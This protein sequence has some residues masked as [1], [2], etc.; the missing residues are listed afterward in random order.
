M[1]WV[2]LKENSCYEIFN[3]YPF[4][5]RDKIHGE[6]IKQRKTAEGCFVRIN[7]KKFLLHRI[8]ANNFVPN[9]ENQHRVFHIDNDKFNNHIE[10]LRWGSGKV[11][12]KTND[13]KKQ[14]KTNGDSQQQKMNEENEKCDH[15]EVVECVDKIVGKAYLI[16]A[17]GYKLFTDYYLYHDDILHFNGERFEILKK[18]DKGNNWEVKM[19][20]DDDKPYMITKRMIQMNR[21]SFLETNFDKL[22]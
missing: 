21:S 17:I 22:V 8:I 2:E 16:N 6:V 18:H 15:L 14:Q 12:A 10:N 13:K 20:C 9:P 3:E 5:I 4:E 19:I 7:G 1:T 11:K